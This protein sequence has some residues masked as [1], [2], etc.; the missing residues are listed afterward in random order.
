MISSREPVPKVKRS[1]ISFAE[2]LRLATN[3][4]R[5]VSVGSI[6]RRRISI[7]MALISMR[8]SRVAKTHNS[9]SQSNHGAVVTVRHRV[10]KLAI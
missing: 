10:D 3:V 7:L 9:M 2:I 5:A 6:I 8:I 1:C 4:H